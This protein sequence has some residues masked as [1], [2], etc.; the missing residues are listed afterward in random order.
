MHPQSLF[1]A[2][3]REHERATAQRVREHQLTLRRR[4]RSL[5]SAR[6][7]SA[8]PRHQRSVRAAVA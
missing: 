2:L 3:V 4:E 8:A 7:R 5:P 1:D 6:V